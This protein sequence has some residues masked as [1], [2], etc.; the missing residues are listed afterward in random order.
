[1]KTVN[2]LGVECIVDLDNTYSNK[3]KAILLTEKVTGEP[4]CT[5][6]VN[7]PSLGLEDGEIAI[8]DYSENEG[9]LECLIENK[10]VEL[11]RYEDDWPIVK[12]I[13]DDAN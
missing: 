6:S 13:E 7:L 11:I 10:I 8:K 9:I 3:R 5:A 2:F 1:M 4:M 12:L